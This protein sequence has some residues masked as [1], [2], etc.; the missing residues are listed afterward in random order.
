MF[1]LLYEGIAMFSQTNEY[2]LRVITYLALYPGKPAKNAEIAKVT[3]VP[4]G[5]LYKVLQTLDR[6]G[7][8]HGHRGMHGGF[9]LARP[10]EQISVLDVI[11]AVDPLPRVR[12]CPLCLEGHSINLCSLHKRI[13]QAFARVE[14]AFA[15]ST[16]AELLADAQSAQ[17]MCDRECNRVA[18]SPRNG[19]EKT[20]PVTTSSAEPAN[21]A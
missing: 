20:V 19:A 9:V 10:P 2:A 6:A 3:Q 4:P 13:D 15:K 12:M 18:F 16:I 8:V 14:D 17:P 7:L 1:T 11:T 21:G 5:Y